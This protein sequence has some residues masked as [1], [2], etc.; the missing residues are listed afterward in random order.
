MKTQTKTIAG[1]KVTLDKG[2]RYVA[3]R[4]WIEGGRRDYPIWIRRHDR[5]PF[6]HPVMTIDGLSYDE[7]NRF[8]LAFNNGPLS[9][10]GRVW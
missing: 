7:A 10:D 5:D 3:S 9:F 4:P 8:L 6:G 1:R 2:V